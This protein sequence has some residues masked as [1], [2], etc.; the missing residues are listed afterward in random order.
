MCVRIADAVGIKFYNL[1]HLALLKG[2]II[3]SL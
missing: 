1:S 2:A 3:K